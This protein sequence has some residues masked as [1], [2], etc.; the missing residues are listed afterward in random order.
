MSV[1]IG[2]AEDNLQEFSHCTER[3]R[4][5]TQV[6]KPWVVNAFSHWAVSA[7]QISVSLDCITVE[8]LVL[9]WTLAS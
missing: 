9:K 2:R 8:S 7:A 3:S 6:V 5:W 4:E 1:H